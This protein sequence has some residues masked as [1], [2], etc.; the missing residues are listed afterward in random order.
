ML[1][2]NNYGE[3]SLKVKMKVRDV[4]GLLSTWAPWHPWWAKY[5]IIIFW[6]LS[7]LHSF[8]FVLVK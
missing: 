7:Y 2:K 6:P 3:N 8:C 4:Q 5:P 1:I